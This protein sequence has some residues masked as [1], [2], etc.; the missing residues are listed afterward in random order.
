MILSMK[1]GLEQ[2]LEMTKT[3]KQYR[4]QVHAVSSQ[5]IQQTQAIQTGKQPPTSKINNQTV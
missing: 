3:L 4:G 5:S 1:F 2:F